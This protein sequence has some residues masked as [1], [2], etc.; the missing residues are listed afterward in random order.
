MNTKDRKS[1]TINS[2]SI[3]IEVT[4]GDTKSIMKWIIKNVIGITVITRTSNWNNAETRYIKIPNI[5]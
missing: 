1:S 3:V 4:S 5:E 2:K